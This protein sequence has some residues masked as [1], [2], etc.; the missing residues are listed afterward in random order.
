MDGSKL[1]QHN[2]AYKYRYRMGSWRTARIRRAL[3]SSIPPKTARIICESPS[4]QVLWPLLQESL[5]NPVPRP[6][7]S[8]AYAS[9]V[10]FPKPAQGVLP[11]RAGSPFTGQDLHPLDD[12]QSFMEA[13]HPPI[14]F[15]QP[16]LVA[17]FFLSAR[18]A[19]V[20]R[21]GD[22]ARVWH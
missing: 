1:R 5:C 4:P 17:L 20:Y 21:P 6:A 3:G 8:H 16:C 12:T 19:M 14:P 11:V 7:R 22:S 10:L 18:R 13:S 9:P 15:D 2:S